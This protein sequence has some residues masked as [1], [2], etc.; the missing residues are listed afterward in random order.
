MWKSF[1]EKHGY[2]IKEILQDRN[3]VNFKFKSYQ[4]KKQI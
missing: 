4:E 3:N 1:V 2:T